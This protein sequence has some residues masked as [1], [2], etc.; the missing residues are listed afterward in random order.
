MK[1]IP[2]KTTTVIVLALLGGA[3]LAQL[4]GVRRADLLRHDIAVPGREV[5]QMRVEID[6][7]HGVPKHTHPGDE[8]F[9]VIEGTLEYQPEGKPAVTLGSGQS[10]FIPA[11]TVHAARNT[12]TGN[13]AGI[14][15]Y[16]VE[17]GKPLITVVK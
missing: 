6:P 16:I 4:A 17:K 9:H 1:A 15:T 10:V 2:V 12:G 11:G 7:G 3:A 14:A 5:V 8:V 13:G